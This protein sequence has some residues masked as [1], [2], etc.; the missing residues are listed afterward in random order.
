MADV[1]DSVRVEA[2]A[3]ALVAPGDNPLPLTA[4]RSHDGRASLPMLSVV[5][6]E[7]GQVSVPGFG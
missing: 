7:P 5:E 4:W 6:G 1:A 2:H 3:Y